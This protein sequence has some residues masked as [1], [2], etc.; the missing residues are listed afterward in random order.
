MWEVQRPTSA[1]GRVWSAVRRLFCVKSLKYKPQARTTYTVGRRIAFR[2][3][4][5]SN[6]ACGFCFV[7]CSEDSREGNTLLVG[8]IHN[9]T[10]ATEGI[11]RAEFLREPL[12]KTTTKNSVP[13]SWVGSGQALSEKF[14]DI[15]T[16]PWLPNSIDCSRHGLCHSAAQLQQ[17]LTC[18]RAKRMLD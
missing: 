11:S 10:K 9:F 12:L 15:H 5:G 7:W 3:T 8:S 4:S 14:D 16:S 6:T 18:A 1:L 2:L 17:M 13:T